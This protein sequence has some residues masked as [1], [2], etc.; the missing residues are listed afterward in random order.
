MNDF[1]VSYLDTIDERLLEYLDE[2]DELSLD[3]V[4]RLRLYA[5]A[6]LAG[7][8]TPDHLAE[9]W[10]DW[11]HLAPAFV[12]AYG[13]EELEK[14]GDATDI[15]DSEEGQQ[16]IALTKADRAYL[17]ALE[18]RPTCTARS[19]VAQQAHSAGN[20][21]SAASFR[22]WSERCRYLTRR[23]DIGVPEQAFHDV[24]SS[25]WRSRLVA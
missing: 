10:S 2:D 19:G 25:P 7:S 3:A 21:R 5:S 11:F 4:K 13:T 23:G 12:L 8:V 20:A 16:G 24:E 22:S 6:L 15:L 1:L 14:L 18:A 9:D 17:V